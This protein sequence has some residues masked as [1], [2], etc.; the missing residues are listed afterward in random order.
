[1]HPPETIEWKKTGLSAYKILRDFAK[2]DKNLLNADV[3]EALMS[4]FE[5]SSQIVTRRWWWGKSGGL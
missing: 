3:V 2:V 1:M 4:V 5:A